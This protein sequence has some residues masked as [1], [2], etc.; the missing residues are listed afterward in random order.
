M[1]LAGEFL[2]KR[3]LKEINKNFD[4][5]SDGGL[6]EIGKKSIQKNLEIV[7]KHG[8]QIGYARGQ[9]ESRPFWK[10][11]K[12]WVM[13]LGVVIPLIERYTNANLTTEIIFTI[14]G[15]LGAYLAGQSWHDHG[16]TK[17]QVI[18]IKK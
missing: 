2:F 17:R 7:K 11:K 8:E 6:D 13:V 16:K 4:K 10:S 5:V 14:E 12:F 3:M 9:A 18:E 15:V 1:A